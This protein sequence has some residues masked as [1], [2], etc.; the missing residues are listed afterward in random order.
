M[1]HNETP[2][3]TAAVFHL[4][5][6]RQNI[7]VTPPILK[8]EKLISEGNTI[9]TPIPILMKKEPATEA[10][11]S[12]FMQTTETADFVIPIL[13]PDNNENNTESCFS[14]LPRSVRFQGRPR[15]PNS[16][17]TLLDLACIG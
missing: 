9:V 3:G 15:S 7:R 12:V 10:T 8:S 11:L 4:P 5:N 14:L 13:I 16:V 17:C 1:L 6:E 2:T